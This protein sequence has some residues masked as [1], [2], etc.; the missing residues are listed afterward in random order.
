MNAQHLPLLRSVRSVD[1]RQRFIVLP[2]P[3]VAVECRPDMR[4][5]F[6][7]GEAVWWYL[8]RVLM[9]FQAEYSEQDARRLLRMPCAATTERTAAFLAALQEARIVASAP[10][11][12]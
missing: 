10:G 12:A 4:A 5:R 9:P 11:G 8:R 1:W 3:A 6:Q 7:S 2:T